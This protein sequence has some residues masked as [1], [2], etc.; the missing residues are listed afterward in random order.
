MR[1]IGLKMLLEMPL[2]RPADTL[3]QPDEMKGIRHS[4]KAI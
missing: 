1:L 3:S 2:A 4:L